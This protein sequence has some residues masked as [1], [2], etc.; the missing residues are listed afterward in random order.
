M[1]QLVELF[2]T[3]K[4]PESAVKILLILFAIKLFEPGAITQVKSLALFRTIL[5]DTLVILK[6]LSLGMYFYG[7]AGF[8]LFLLC[9]IISKLEDIFRRQT[10]SEAL[11]PFGWAEATYDIWSSGIVWAWILVGYTYIFGGANRLPGFVEVFQLNPKG[12]QIIRH[13]VLVLINGVVM[14][15][16]LWRFITDIITLR[17]NRELINVDIPYPITVKGELP[18]QSRDVML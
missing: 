13:S 11:L 12:V 6:V 8:I 15:V 7:I 16:F 5:P 2:K 18:H 9:L 17:I 14:L 10:V 4:E 1:L 3:I